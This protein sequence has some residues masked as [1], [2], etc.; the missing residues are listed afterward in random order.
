M[1]RKWEGHLNLGGSNHMKFRE[2][3]VQKCPSTALSLNVAI[4]R[5]KTTMQK[6]VN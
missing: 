3:M 6:V 2:V 5:E 4:V 1:R